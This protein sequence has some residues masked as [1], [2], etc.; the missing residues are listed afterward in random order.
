[1]RAG[2]RERESEGERQ[3]QRERGQREAERERAEGRGQLYLTSTFPTSTFP[4]T[5]SLTTHSPQPLTPVHCSPAVRPPPTHSPNT[6]HPLTPQPTHPPPHSPPTPPSHS[7]AQIGP[8]GQKVCRGFDCD[9]PRLLWSRV[10]RLCRCVLFSL[11]RPSPSPISHT[12]HASPDLTPAF[13]FRGAFSLSNSIVPHMPHSHSPPPHSPP[14]PA[15][16]PDP[17]LLCSC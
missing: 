17:V 8:R 7:L 13:V 1:M 11:T 10:Y 3:R 14:I 15:F 12:S 2:G 16:A 9:A 4:S 5:I 6:P